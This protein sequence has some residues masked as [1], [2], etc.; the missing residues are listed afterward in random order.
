MFIN[1]EIS[2]EQLSNKYQ[3]LPRLFKLGK[4]IVQDADTE[5]NKEHL[6][7]LLG[8][9]LLYKQCS[10][11]VLAGLMYNTIPDEQGLADFLTKAT[12][13]DFID[14]NGNKFVTKFLVSDEE[15]KKLDMYCYP[16]PMLIEPKE[17]KNNKQDGYYLQL[18]TGIILKNNRTNDD[19]NL[20][21]IN[22]ENKIKLELNKYAVLNNHN[23]WSCD[24]A[25]QMN[26]QMFDR[27]N[28]AQQEI[29]TCYKD[30][31]FYLTWKYDKRGRSYS[32]GYHINIQSNDYGKSLINFSHKEIIEN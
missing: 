4:A 8:F 19:V 17:I 2:I 24:M 6:A 32:Q 1:Q 10:P 25:N 3:L 27:F 26:K 29:L 12:V 14:F 22:K 31:T 30:R 28:L 13:E 9:L 7:K 15:Q 11:S 20:D 16:L 23:E 21:Y 5:L 18:N